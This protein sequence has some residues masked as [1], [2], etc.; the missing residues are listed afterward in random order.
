[1]ILMTGCVVAY[2]PGRQPIGDLCTAI[3]ERI[4]LSELVGKIKDMRAV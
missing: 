2:Y 3:A 4:E 1:M